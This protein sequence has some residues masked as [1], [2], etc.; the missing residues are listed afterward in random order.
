MKINMRPSKYLLDN[1]FSQEI[2]QLTECNAPEVANHF[3][4]A[5]HWVGNFFLNS[6]LGCSIDQKARAFGF[7]FLRRAETAFVEYEIARKSLNDFVNS[8]GEKPFFYLKSL[9][10]FEITVT[11]LYQS[12]QLFI[13][14]S[15]E[16]LFEKND[17]SVLERLNKIYNQIRHFNPSNLP[18]N[19]FHPMWITN[20]GI[21]TEN[22]S[23]SFKEFEETMIEIGE[24]ADTLS[25][26]EK[27]K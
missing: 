24:L 7:G 26:L 10:H 18:S 14:L 25:K 19:H 1:F 16:K 5:E 11:M 2:S 21:Q 3:S 22:C 23:L 27:N 15:Y 9:T 12:Y 4:Q 13:R 8:N 20:E 6:V 17:G